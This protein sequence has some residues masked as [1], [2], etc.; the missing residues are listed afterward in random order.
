[1][2]HCS[3]HTPTVSSFSSAA[4]RLIVEVAKRW[5]EQDDKTALPREI[6]SKKAFEN[7]MTL[8]VAMGGIDQH[9][10]TPARR[11]HKRRGWTLIWQ[12]STRYRA[13]CHS[14]A[15]SL[16]ARRSITWRMCIR[17]GGVMAIL[18]ELARGNLLH[19]DCPYGPQ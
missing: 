16:R 15:K 19:L 12:T 2:A 14:C 9:D 13:K 6:A 8:D 5:Y 17:A 10:P 1:M 18:G 11:Q 7:A 4:G 3:P